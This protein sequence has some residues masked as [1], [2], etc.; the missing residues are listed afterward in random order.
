MLIG[1]IIGYAWATRKHGAFSGCKRV[2]VKPQS[3]AITCHV[4]RLW[5]RAV[6]RRIVG[7]LDN[8]SRA[9]RSN[10]CSL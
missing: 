9:E 4:T 10:Y 3:S 2:I 8:A 6:P 7:R 1:A 5:S